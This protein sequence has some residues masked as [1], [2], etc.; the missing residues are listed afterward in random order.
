MARKRGVDRAQVVAA[1][2]AVVE[3]DGLGALTL[4]R[5]AET[6]DVRSPSLYSHVDGLAGLRRAVALE[7]AQALGAAMAGAVATAGEGADALRS[8]AHAYRHFARVHPGLYAAMLPVPDVAE[9]AEGYAAFAEPVDVV[10]RVL[11]D[12][13][14]PADLTVAVVRAFRSALHGFVSLEAG[15]GFRQPVDVDRSFDLLV[16]ILV[17]GVLTLVP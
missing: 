15:G 1:A 11:A 14:V 16:D 8:I 4:A 10:A 17:A 13:A 12:L 9:D 6:L 2:V 5:V 7:A 3:G